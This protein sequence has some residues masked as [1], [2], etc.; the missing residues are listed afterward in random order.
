VIDFR[1]LPV[2]TYIKAAITAAVLAA[3]FG[4][5]VSCGRKVG[6]AQVDRQAKA[7][8]KT[9]ATI[10]AKTEKARQAMQAYTSYVQDRYADAAIRYES[11]KVAAFNRG[12]DT[13]L[14]VRRGDLRLRDEWACPRP[15][16]GDVQ[17]APVPGGPDHTADLRAASAGRIVQIGADADALVRL[18]RSTLDAIYA[19][20]GAHEAPRDR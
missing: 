7:H 2:V 9:L 18:C 19:K 14:A 10:A 8:A 6:Q 11:D 12:R 5:G 15:A 4:T 16:A 3:V 17:A 20:A 1:A 13:A